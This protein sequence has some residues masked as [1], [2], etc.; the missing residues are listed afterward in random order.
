MLPPCDKAKDSA[1][2]QLWAKAEED[3][4][5]AWLLELPIAHRAARALLVHHEELF[6][7]IRPGVDGAPERIT[8]E[9]FIWSSH[10]IEK[11]EHAL[12]QVRLDSERTA[13]HDANALIDQMTSIVQDSARD[14]IVLAGLR[15]VQENEIFQRLLAGPKAS[16]SET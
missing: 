5:V 2:A 9:Y 4:A 14:G 7:T 12:A 10:T 16:S 3:E 1:A 13:A 8:A 6:P 11:Q 15:S